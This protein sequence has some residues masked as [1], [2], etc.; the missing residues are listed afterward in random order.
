MK[1]RILALLLGTVFATS[2]LL[3][4]V[5]AEKDLAPSPTLSMDDEQ[6]RAITIL[7][8]LIV[9]SEEI[10]ASKNSRLFLDN[11]YE[12]LNNNMDLSVLD[13]DSFSEVKSLLNTIHAYQMLDVKRQRLQFIYEQNQAQEIKS[14]I[15]NPVGLLSAVSSGNYIKMLT[16]VIYMAVD[17]VASYESTKNEI[18][19]SYLQ[20]GWALDDEES[21]QLHQANIDAL[22]YM[23]DIVQQY[24]LPIQ[25]ALNLKSV[26]SFINWKNDTNAV[27]RIQ[28]LEENKDVYS[29]Y[30]NYWLVLAENYY[31]NEDYQKCLDCIDE[32]ENLNLAIFRNDY[33]LAQTLPLVIAAAGELLEGDDYVDQVKHYA[34]LITKNADRENWILKYFAAQTYMDLYNRTKDSKYL[35]TAYDLAKSNINTLVKEQVALNETYMADV[36]EV[37]PKKDATK[38]EKSECKE[39]NS[40]LKKIRKTELP[41]VNTSLVVN[42]DLLFAIADELDIDKD[43]K[44]T[45]NKI[46][47]DNGEALFLIPG[48][49]DLYWFDA[50]KNEEEDISI[51][52]D[53]NTIGLPA[54][55]I[56]SDAVIKAFV[57][58]DG[59]E[60]EITDWIIEKV[61]RENEEDLNSFIAEFESDELD[62]YEYQEGSKVTIEIYPLGIDPEETSLV[63]K[64]SIAYEV[65]GFETTVVENAAGGIPVIE[66]LAGGVSEAYRFISGGADPI[67]TRTE[68]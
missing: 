51:V 64:I 36:Q 20:D 8:Y 7:N 68:S 32:Y 49:D 31:E 66:L 67:F 26:E 44:I 40:M 38:E 35:S 65:T 9:M 61:S 54:K 22:D 1:N 23:Y 12:A 57:V 52:F 60:A 15:P 6:L 13:E 55:W 10:N 21:E 4:T 53:K 63:E 25:Y 5:A 47:H 19:L 2:S 59:E 29:A 42:C 28:F 27:R 56:S 37:E 50:V 30:G 17:S 34:E 41:P 33:E 3:Q 18:E 39:Y 11:A 24:N 58:T 14:A 62:D 43:E 16:S 45:I 48:L 46:L